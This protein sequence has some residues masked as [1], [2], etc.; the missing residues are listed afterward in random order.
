MT[1]EEKPAEAPAP[2]APVVPKSKPG[3]WKGKTKNLTMKQVKG[4]VRGLGGKKPRKVTSAQAKTAMSNTV[5]IGTTTWKTKEAR[6]G[7]GKGGVLVGAD[8]K[9]VTGTV[10]LPGGNKATYVDGKR[11]S[12]PK[13][14]PA[15]PSSPRPG[16][17]SGRPSSGAGKPGSSDINTKSSLVNGTPRP[18]SGTKPTSDQSEGM[19][20]Q[21]SIDKGVSNAIGIKPTAD[22]SERMVKKKDNSPEIEPYKL[23]FASKYAL[24][25]VGLDWRDVEASGQAEREGLYNVA[26]INSKATQ[27]E[28][29]LDYYTTG[30]KK[31]VDIRNPKV[32][33]IAERNGQPIMWT[34]KEWSTFSKPDNT[35][36]KLGQTRT[37]ANGKKYGWNGSSWSYLG[38][39]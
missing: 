7:K 27:R 36:L 20:L 2:A 4:G 33:D 14:K 30:V 9:R 10:T 32:Y 17:G 34:G 39:V 24:T 23:P 21:N 38:R 3:N 6:G 1:E 5:D 25:A 31:D 26:K 11:V 12:A 35:K 15:S 22:Q 18:G 28:A 29:V 16:T 13:K 19:N 8:G 37:L